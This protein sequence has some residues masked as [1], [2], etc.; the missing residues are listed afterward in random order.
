MSANLQI[1]CLPSEYT[2]S[3]GYNSIFDQFTIFDILVD[4]SKIGVIGSDC[5]KIFP[6]Q[7]GAHQ[8]SIDTGRWKSSPPLTVEVQDGMTLALICGMDKK[9]N[10]YVE[11]DLPSSVV[12]QRLEA[13]SLHNNGKVNLASGGFLI[14]M[15]GFLIGAFIISEIDAYIHPGIGLWILIIILTCPTIILFAYGIS[16]FYKKISNR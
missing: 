13:E 12:V 16:W 7:S 5:T 15:I 4:K 11:R 3:M 6:V 9:A 14:A 8:I 10:L 2:G 1:T